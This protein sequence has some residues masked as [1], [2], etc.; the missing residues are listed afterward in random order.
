MPHNESWYTPK[1]NIGS[2]AEPFHCTFYL[3]TQLHGHSVQNY[4]IAYN[5]SITA[6]NDMLHGQFQTLSR[7]MYILRKP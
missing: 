2:S 5:F 3:K 1:G 6:G 7:S 4:P